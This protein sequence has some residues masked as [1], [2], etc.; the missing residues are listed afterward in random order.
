M[1][2]TESNNFCALK[3]QPMTISISPL[4][5]YVIH[6]TSELRHLIIPSCQRIVDSGRVSEIAKDLQS[7][8]KTN[9]DPIR[10]QCLCIVILPDKTEYLIDGQH[11]LNAYIKVLDETKH[12]LAVC[13]N[14][15]DVE[16]HD[17]VVRLF[18]LVN[19]TVSLAE[20]PEGIT[21]SDVNRLSSEFRTKYPTAFGNKTRRPMIGYSDFEE[22]IAN[23]KLHDLNDDQIRCKLD[24]FTKNC[25]SKTWK[26]FCKYK[27]D[28]AAHVDS[29][30][31]KVNHF[32]LGLFS[33][34]KWLHI[35]HPE[36]PDEPF[37]RRSNIPKALR[38]KVWNTYMGRGA[39]QG[40]C[41]FCQIIISLE[42]FHCAHDISD[43]QDGEC[44]I[45][46]L[47]PCCALCNLSLGIRSF[48]ECKKLWKR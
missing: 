17:E 37:I 6:Q 19:K 26:Y 21:Q 29:M 1:R 31:H 9:I 48:E 38:L 11:R 30:R 39:R 25:A 45:D 44:S 32:C 42:V 46:N 22:L 34:D 35:V 12:D 23:L 24:Q 28:T 40:S 47:Y 14:K 36:I 15:I 33:K 4:Q 20:L 41:P 16:N 3:K 27:T 7:Y 8:L 2:R 18:Q 10:A 43:S 13:V 5:K